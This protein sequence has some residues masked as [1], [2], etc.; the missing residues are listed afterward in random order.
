MGVQR[1]RLADTVGTASPE[2]IYYLI[3]KCG[4][5]LQSVKN[6]PIVGLH[7]HNDFGLALA[8]VFAGV[9]AGATLIDVSVNG[10][11]DRSGNPS[12]A[13]VACGLEVLYG[14]KTECSAG[15]A[16]AGLSK[17]VET[18]SGVPIPSNKPLVGEYAFAD[19]S[20]AHVAAQLQEPLPSRGFS[21]SPSATGGRYVLGKNSGKN[22]LRWKFQELNLEVR[23]E[24]YPL[25]L[26]RIR[27]ASEKRKGKPVSDEE[28]REM[29]RSGELETGG[30][31]EIRAIRG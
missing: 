31:G 1:I 14:V 17:F 22:I 10:L 25:I 19:E 4:E 18:I 7:C 28:L 26:E 27:E 23:E 21:R 30:T 3:Q 11:G 8:N 12:L 29:V 15:S 20:D 6:P 2:G 16:F 13:E 5:T 9:R 24:L